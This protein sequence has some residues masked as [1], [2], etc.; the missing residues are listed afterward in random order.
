MNEKYNGW[1]V[2]DEAWT[3]LDKNTKWYLIYG[4]NYYINGKA[5]RIEFTFPEVAEHY[6]LLH[7]DFTSNRDIIFGTYDIEEMKK[8]INNLKFTDENK[9][10]A[11][12]VDDCITKTIYKGET[13]VN[14]FLN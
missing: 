7:I 4:S 11:L 1:K 8:F 2:Y 13:F 5:N 10:R 6:Y 9:R 12:F 3:N 14:T